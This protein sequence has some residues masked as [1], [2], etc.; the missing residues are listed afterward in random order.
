LS[1]W[2]KQIEKVG[3]H[4]PQFVAVPVSAS[5]TATVQAAIEIELDGLMLR[6]AENVDALYVAQLVA[7]LQTRGAGRC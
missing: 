1:Y 4:A 3:P 6:V 7:A 2:A 5:R